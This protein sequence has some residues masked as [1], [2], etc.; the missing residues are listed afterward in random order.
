MGSH[1]HSWMDCLA[2]KLF[3]NS[4][5]SDTVFVTLFRTAVET[6]LAEYTSCFALATALNND[7]VL[8]VADN[9]LGFFLNIFL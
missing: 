8:A 5:F 7:T 2:A 4:C 1:S 3:L 9:L 6:P